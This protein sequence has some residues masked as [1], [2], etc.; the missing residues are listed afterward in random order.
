MAPQMGY[1]SMFVL[2]PSFALIFPSCIASIGEHICSM[3]IHHTG[4]GEVHHELIFDGI[5]GL[6][7][8]IFH[9]YIFIYLW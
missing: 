8:Q 9:L 3:P 6:S 2:I 4:L 7:L 5:N 1:K